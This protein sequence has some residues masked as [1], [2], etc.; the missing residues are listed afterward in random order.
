M[1]AWLQNSIGRRLPVIGD[2]VGPE[3][4]GT[5][6]CDCGV[7]DQSAGDGGRLA[8]KMSRIAPRRAGGL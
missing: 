6:D 8:R 3:P 4:L 5:F 7:W 2:R 1:A